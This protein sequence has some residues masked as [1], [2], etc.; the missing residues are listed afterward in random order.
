M[1]LQS[2]SW[3]LAGLIMYANILICW[4]ELNLTQR[5]GLYMVILDGKISIFDGFESP[6]VWNYTIFAQ[7]G[8]AHTQHQLTLQ[9]AAIQDSWLDVDYMI[10]TVGEGPSRYAHWHASYFL[11]NHTNKHHTEQHTDGR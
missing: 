1:D 4:H 8:L 6:D 5:Q 7:S 3:V 9:A 2:T 11:T 10:I